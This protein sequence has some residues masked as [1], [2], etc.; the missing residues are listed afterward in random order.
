MSDV[1]YLHGFLS[2]PQSV[3]AQATKAWFARHYPQVT[4]HTPQLPNSPGQVRPQLERYI[5]Q[6]PQLLEQGLKVIGSSMGGYLASHLVEHYGGRAALVNPAVRPYELLLE[7]LGD[8]INPYTQEPFSLVTDDMHILKSLDTPIVSQPE[9]YLVLLQT[10]DETLDYRQA[11]QKY[12]GAQLRIE[13]G[14]D[15]SFENYEQHLPDI[16]RFLAV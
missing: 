7:Y 16:A 11:E 2:S 15:H 1:L 4:L 8:H 6:H 5:E 3:K 14:G 12:Q 9:Q 13:Q 10:G